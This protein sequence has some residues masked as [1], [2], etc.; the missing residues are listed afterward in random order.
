MLL[1]KILIP[2]FVPFQFILPITLISW[3][4]HSIKQKLQKLPTWNKASQ[5]K[6]LRKTNGCAIE[7]KND[8]AEAAALAAPDAFEAKKRPTIKRLSRFRGSLARPVAAE[9]ET[10]EMVRGVT[11]TIPLHTIVLWI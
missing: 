8:E 10:I 11:Y 3:A 9:R 4:H 5:R 7:A 2:F 1:V 6:S